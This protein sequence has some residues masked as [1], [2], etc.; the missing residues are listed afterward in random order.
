VDQRVVA[1]PDLFDSRPL[2]YVQC[3]S[4]GNLVFVS[5][6]SG[7][8]ERMQ[9]VSPEF[10]SQARQTLLNVARALDA[11]GAR[12]NDITALTIYLT[13]MA[14]LRTFGAVRQE[15]LGEIQATSTAV[16]VSALAM[17]EM[18]VEVTVMAVRQ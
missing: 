13:D 6:Q 14:N 11:A 10:E 7:F 5:G 16:E 9:L 2:G 15:V 18:L 8:D 12:P 1:V 4:A 3:V 17:P